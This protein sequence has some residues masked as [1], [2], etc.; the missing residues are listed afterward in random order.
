[1]SRRFLR[2][3]IGVSLVSLLFG[4]SGTVVPARAEVQKVL[5][6]CLKGKAKEICP[7]FRASFKPP[8]GWVEDKIA[9]ARQGRVVWVPKGR[10][11]DNAPNVLSAL[12][13]IDKQKVPLSTFESREIDAFKQK[14]ANAVQTQLPAIANPRLGGTVKVAKLTAPTRK[15][16]PIQ[17]IAQFVDKDADDS[18]FVVQ[19]TLDAQTEAA[20]AEARPKFDAMIKTY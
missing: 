15:P 5:F 18:P 7:Q 11:F 14:F 3:G 16:R 17:L 1:M 12:V 2:S 10:S 6:V 4:I 20:L 13:Q 9:G 19:L 8:D